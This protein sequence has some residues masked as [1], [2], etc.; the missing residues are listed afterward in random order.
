MAGVP[1]KC[2]AGFM[3]ASEDFHVWSYE[4]SQ[5]FRDGIHVDHLEKSMRAFGNGFIHVADAME[6]CGLNTVSSNWT[7]VFQQIRHHPSEGLQLLVTSASKRLQAINVPYLVILIDQ[8]LKRGLQYEAAYKIGII[9]GTI[10]TPNTP[11]MLLTPDS[12]HALHRHIA[13]SH[14]LQLK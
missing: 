1:L 13:L 2:D 10:L 5:I 12:I 3:N 6:F 7:R 8:D 9:I 11:N 14:N 4:F